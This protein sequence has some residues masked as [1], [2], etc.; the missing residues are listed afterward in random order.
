[1]NSQHDQL[2]VG[3]IAQLV[4]HCTGIAEV[5]VPIPFKHDFFFSL[6]FTAAYAVRKTAMINHVFISLSAGQ[7]HVISYVHLYTR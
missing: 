4:E 7:I 6:N 5:R 1:M 2:P 3:L